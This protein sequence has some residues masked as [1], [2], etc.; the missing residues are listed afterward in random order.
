[1]T[2]PEMMKRANQYVTAEALMAEKRKDQKQPQTES[3]RGPPPGIPSKRTERA[4]QAV[5]RLPNTPL[6]STRTEIILQ[7]QEKGLLKTP[8]PMRSRAEERNRIEESLRPNRSPKKTHSKLG[9]TNEDLTPMIS[10]LTGFTRD[11]I[12]PAGIA[13]LPMTFD[14]EPRTKTLIVSFMVVELPLAYNV[15]IG[16]LTL[17]KLRA[18]ISTYHHS[19]KFPTNAGAGEV[20]NDPRESR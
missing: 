7:I 12:A 20:R 13:T 18:V 4:E 15:I 11:A 5:P 2:I 17:N 9:R 16:R 3:S 1:M 6:N 19:M 10:T 8:N 14:D